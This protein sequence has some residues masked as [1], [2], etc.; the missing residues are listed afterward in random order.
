VAGVRGLTVVGT[1]VGPG[2]FEPAEDPGCSLATVTPM[3]AAAPPAT[4]T[5]VLVRRVTR[6][7]ARARAVGLY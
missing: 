1:E 3:N 4:R 2:A 6:A 5:A 7:C